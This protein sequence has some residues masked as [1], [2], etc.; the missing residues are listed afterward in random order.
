MEPD[1]PS[2]D[3]DEMAYF[4]ENCAEYGLP[5]DGAAEVRR[6]HH[7]VGDATVAALHWGSG[8]ARV[9]L[10]H[11]SAQNAHTW[12]T[13]ALALRPTPLVAV[14]LPGHG[15]SSWRADGRYDPR[16]NAET[17]EVALEAMVGDGRVATPFVLVGMSLG[18]LTA[19]S[20]AARRPDLVERMVVVDITPGVTRD[21][22]KEIHDFVAGPQTFGSFSEI[23][24]R[25]VQFNPTRTPESLRRGILHNAHRLEAGGWEW[26]YHRAEPSPEQ[27]PDRDELWGDVAS[28]AMP[29]LLVRGAD[30]PVV[31][32]DDVEHLRGT[33]PDARVEVVESAG[34]S[35]QGDRPLEL[36]SLVRRE[37]DGG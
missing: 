34:H 22:A 20:V 9:V 16:T 7:P 21:K 29:Y 25:T 28:T 13:V 26:N 1:D 12:D 19:N 11:G 23:F 18:G 36:A 30:S 3:Y 15:R 17:V 27:F 31:D 24:E 14:D 4:G 8:P 2:F 6:I 37:I 5:W 33:R 10:L 32:D 35:V